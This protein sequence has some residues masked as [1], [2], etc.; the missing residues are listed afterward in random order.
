[1]RAPNLPKP[2]ERRANNLVY[3]LRDYPRAEAALRDALERFPDHF[4]LICLQ[5]L[6]I[7]Y[8]QGRH[9]DAVQLYER[10]LEIDDEDA[11]TWANNAYVLA[12]SGGIQQ[13]IAAA[14][15]ALEVAGPEPDE[16]ESG[17]CVEAAFY[18]YALAEP[19]GRAGALAGLREL[20]EANE[21]TAEWNF[22]PIIA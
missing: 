20:L 19:S 15:R 7:G 22:G 6:V 1:K 18:L 12:C 14:T 16:D 11:G 10:A 13:A 17:P 2:Q 9:G 21:S 8:V 3:G 5:A 4:D